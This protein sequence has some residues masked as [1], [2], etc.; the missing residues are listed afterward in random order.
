M[1]SGLSDAFLP[2]RQGPL[3]GDCQTEPLR[4][5]FDRRI[6]LEF[7]G[8][9]V[10]SDAGLLA[11]RDRAV[12]DRPRGAIGHPARRPPRFPAYLLDSGIRPASNTGSGDPSEVAD[13]EVKAHLGI[14]G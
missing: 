6:R 5:Q 4:P 7:H 8:A 12:G 3:M 9:N 2:T 14:P 13:G 11:Y 10:T 1:F